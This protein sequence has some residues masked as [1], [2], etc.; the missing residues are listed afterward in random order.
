[1]TQLWVTATRGTFEN[2]DLQALYDQ[3]TAS[4]GQSVADAL[5]AGVAI[6]EIDILDLQGQL[7]EIENADIQ[8]VYANLLTRLRQ[9]SCVPS[10]PM[11]SGRPARQSCLSTCEQDDF[12]KIMNGSNGRKG[13]GFNGD[14]HGGSQRD[15]RGGR[16]PGGGQAGRQGA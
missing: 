3:L 13:N 15:N 6:E 7:T 14:G 8:R 2:Q 5:L 11:L 10:S 12:D 9:P 1:M 16:G 4:G